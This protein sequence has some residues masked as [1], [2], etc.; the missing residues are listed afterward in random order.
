MRGGGKLRVTVSGVK[1]AEGY[2]LYMADGEGKSFVLAATLTGGTLKYTVGGLSNSNN[3][4]F[5]V[6]SYITMGRSK[7]Y[8]SFSEIQKSNVL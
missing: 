6:R 7:V 5:K 2:E 3:Y 8:S 4:Y 1:N